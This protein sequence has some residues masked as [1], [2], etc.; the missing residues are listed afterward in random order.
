MASTEKASKQVKQLKNSVNVSNHRFFNMIIEGVQ[1][2]LE[3]TVP[4]LKLVQSAS[5]LTKD[6]GT[7]VLTGRMTVKDSEEKESVENKVRQTMDGLKNPADLLSTM[8]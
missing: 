8:Q 1:G 3:E 5:S 4:G 2:H 6:G 7:T